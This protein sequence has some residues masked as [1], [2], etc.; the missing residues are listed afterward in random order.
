MQFELSILKHPLETNLREDNSFLPNK[1]G[2]L[3]TLIAFLI[4]PKSVD[5][6]FL[7]ARVVITLGLVLCAVYFSRKKRDDMEII[8]EYKTGNLLF[9]DNKIKLALGNK[10]LEIRPK[11]K[12]KLTFQYFSYYKEIESLDRNSTVHYGTNNFIEING[13]KYFIFLNG[14]VDRK[15]FYAL[16]KWAIENKL[17]IKEFT[18]GERTY[19]GEH[20]NYKQIQEFKKRYS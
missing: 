3:I 15:R 14:T 7:F 10:P 18:K 2:C 20:L 19:M 5:A 12:V 8:E 4:L 11:S 6:P 13:K 9:C 1:S 16:S 17:S